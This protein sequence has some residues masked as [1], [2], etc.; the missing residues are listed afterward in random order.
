MINAL[1]TDQRIFEQEYSAA[2]AYLRGARL[3]KEVFC[4]SRAVNG[5]YATKFDRARLPSIQALEACR[6]PWFLDLLRREGLM[7]NEPM[8][9]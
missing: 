8:E 2:T 1:E 5:G 6:V 7:P 9:I 3:R 4:L